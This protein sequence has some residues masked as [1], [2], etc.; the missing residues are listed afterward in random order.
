MLEYIGNA[1]LRL[2]DG[3]RE[4]YGDRP[5]LFAGGVMSNTQIKEKITKRLH[6]SFAAPALSSDNAV[7]IAALAALAHQREGV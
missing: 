6:A 1:L 7:G 4:R 3:F 5:L 2:C